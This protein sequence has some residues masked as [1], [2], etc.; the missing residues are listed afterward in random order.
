MEAPYYKYGNVPIWNESRWFSD[1]N[2]R[3]TI[4]CPWVNYWIVNPKRYNSFSCDVSWEL[5]NSYSLSNYND[6][7]S[8]LVVMVELGEKIAWV[9]TLR[10][11]NHWDSHIKCGEPM[12]QP[13]KN[14]LTLTS[15]PCV[16][17]IVPM[18]VVVWNQNGMVA[19]NFNSLWWFR[20]CGPP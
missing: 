10:L 3:E 7:S 9:S 16:R 15:K 5:L 1:G 2:L 8:T 17:E 14:Q 6:L 11:D 4:G 13:W 20:Q 19:D 18:F 12:W